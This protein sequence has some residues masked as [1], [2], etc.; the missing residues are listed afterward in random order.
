[1]AVSKLSAS[2]AVLDRD[3]LQIGKTVC[4]KTISTDTNEFGQLQK[5][6]NTSKGVYMAYLNG[7]KYYFDNNGNC[8]TDDNIAIYGVTS[9]SLSIEETSK[10]TRSSGDTVSMNT[11]LPKDYF[12]IEAMG[13]L[14]NNVD[15]VE[16]IDDA[17]VYA[18]VTKA[19]KIAQAMI[20]VGS[21]ARTADE[22]AIDSKVTTTVSGTE[23]VTNLS[24]NTEK[25]LN[26]IY[27]VL[28]AFNNS[29]KTNES[30]NIK[31]PLGTIGT[32]V[33]TVGSNISTTNVRLST[34]AT[35]LDTIADNIENI[36][37]GNGLTY[38][39]TPTATLVSFVGFSATATGGHAVGQTS[40]ASLTNDIR[41]A[42]FNTA[43]SAQYWLGTNG[44]TTIT[45]IDSFLTAY[46]SKIESNIEST[47]LSAVNTKLGDSSSDIY[48]SV[49]AIAET[50]KNS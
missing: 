22:K 41:T 21:D 9:P 10:V 18:L 19:Y 6:D 33:N 17:T 43:S 28:N 50:V 36:E 44:T 2:E 35:K 27:A 38:A 40:M 45:S 46:G 47:I 39:D 5:S 12:A 31:T 37:G 30:D 14:L 4:F 13:M 25:L 23:S 48:K 26:N 7:T 8:A 49:K 1:M 34:I 11:L 3:E 24:S 42:L 20:D 15:N 29:F 32:N 16:S